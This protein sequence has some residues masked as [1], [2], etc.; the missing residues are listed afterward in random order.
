MNVI[1]VQ[2]DRNSSPVM[3]PKDSLPCL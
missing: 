1:V 2:L 3:K